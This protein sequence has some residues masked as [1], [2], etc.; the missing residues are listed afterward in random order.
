MLSVMGK[1]FAILLSMWVFVPSYG[2]CQWR[3][4][5]YVEGNLDNTSCNRI[6]G[7][8]SFYGTGYNF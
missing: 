3:G 5:N 6:D 8:Y 2:L 1:Y 4:E 7:M